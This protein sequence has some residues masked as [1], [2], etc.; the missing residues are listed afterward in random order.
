MNFQPVDA[1]IHLEFTAWNY[2]VLAAR[3]GAVSFTRC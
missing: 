3:S 1:F 2:M